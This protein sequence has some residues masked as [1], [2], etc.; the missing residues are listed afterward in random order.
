MKQDQLR[1][2]AIIM[3]GNKR[4]AMQR[5]LRAIDGHKAGSE[6]LRALYATL[7]KHP[8]VEV[9]TIFA[10]SS[11]NWKR[12]KQ[13][14]GAI[15]SMFHSFLVT[16]RQQIIDDNISLRIIGD[17]NRL[18]KRLCQLIEQIEKDTQKGDFI[19]N[20]AVSYGGRWDIAMAAKKIAHQV[21]ENKLAINDIDEEIFSRY[22]ALGDLPDVDLLIR[23]GNEFRVS[24]FLLWQLAYTEFYFVERYWPDFDSHCLEEAMA[25]YYQRRRRFGGRVEEKKA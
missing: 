14:V 21:Q 7:K 9:L 12:S 20:L 11:E 2:I 13:E 19:L 18:S 5:G 23:T 22:T 10:F 25:M 17:R 1:H 16:Y 4:W 24:N 8:Q 6:C 3:D 15:M